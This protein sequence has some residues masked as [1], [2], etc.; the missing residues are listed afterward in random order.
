MKSNRKYTVVVTLHESNTPCTIRVSVMGRSYNISEEVQVEPF[1]TKKIE[2]YPP[3]L[4]NGDY[5][6]LAEGLNGCMFRNQSKLLIDSDAGPKIYIQTDKSVYKPK[7]L[8]QFRVVILDEHTIPV[9]I[10]EPIRI[11]V[12]DN[13][14]NRV[15]QFKDIVLTEGVFTGRFQLS[16]QPI[17]GKWEIRVTISG[18]YSH[19]NSK[20]ISVQLYTLPKFSVYIQTDENLVLD[21]P[22]IEAEIYGKYTFDKYVQGTLNVELRDFRQNTLIDQQTLRVDGL[23]LVEF[24]LNRNKLFGV[25]TIN[26]QATLEEIDTGVTKSYSQTITVRKDSYKI[27]IPEEEIEF[28]NNKPFRLR[29]HI[30]HWNDGPIWDL[31]TPV[32]MQYGKKTYETYLNEEG[33]AV[34]EFEYRHYTAFIIKFK[35]TNYR[36]PEI[37]IPYD[38][39]DRQYCKIFLKEGPR[40]GKPLEVQVR[41]SHNIPYL[42]YT[43]VGHASI[44]RMDH[45][46]LWRN[47]K[48]YTIKITPSVEMIPKSYLLVYYILDGNLRYDEITLKFPPE[49]E[50]EISITAPKQV[51]PGQELSLN[52]RAQPNSY[53]SI[54]AVDLSV[55]LLDKSY[56]LYKK[57]ILHD[58]EVDKSYIPDDDYIQPGIISGLITLTNAHYPITLEV[59]RS[60][61]AGPGTEWDF[62]TKFPETWIFENYIINN[63][64]TA[65]TLNIP[66]T[67][68]TWRI[69]AFSNNGKTGFG[70]VDGP[71]DITT[72]LPFFITFDL[73]HSVKRDEIVIISVKVFNYHNQSL[74]TR[75][76][77]FNDHSQFHFMEHLPQYSLS[78]QQPKRMTI[79]ANRSKTMKFPIKPSELGEIEIRVAANNSLFTDGI[80]KKLSVIP[81]GITK[82]QNKAIFIN[83]ADDV[84]NSTLILDIPQ[85]IVR[86]SEYI[87][88]AVGGDFMIPTLENL[89]DMIK[90]P[91]GCGEQ[92]MA[93]FAANVLILDYLK[94]T[95]KYL[96]ELELVNQAK[97]YIDM[98]YQQQLSYRHQNGGYSVFGDKHDEVVSTWLTAYVTRF[99][100]KASKYTAIESHI[101]DSA[102]DYLVKE[103]SYDGSFTS[104]GYVIYKELQ[105][106]YSL[107]AFVLLTFMEDR[108]YSRKYQINIQK[109]LEYLSTDLHHISDI[110]TLSLMAT[111]LSKSKH[112]GAHKIIEKLQKLRKESENGLTWWNGNPNDVEVTAYILM[113]LRNTPGNHSP[114]L[115]WLIEQRNEQGGFKS[116]QDTVVGLEALVK[117]SQLYK[118]ADNRNLKILY[119]AQDVKGDEKKINEFIINRE[120]A[121]ILQ[122]HELPKFVRQVSFKI[123]G[124]GY[125]LVQ[126][127][128]Q[129]NIKNDVGIKYFSMKINPNIYDGEEMDLEI[130]FTY[131]ALRHD[132]SNSTNMVIMEANLPTGFKTESEFSRDLVENEFIQRIETKDDDTKMLLYF[133]KLSTE[134]KHCVTIESFKANEVKEYKPAAVVMYDYYNTSRFN[135]EF[136]TI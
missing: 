35:D 103:Q 54:L 36:L 132:I 133:D 24:K 87:T 125:S 27:F 1:E 14:K 8:V 23:V 134:V 46:K 81:E 42:I 82:Y 92:N 77:M 107:T 13:D 28:R 113:S 115:K 49:L 78:P 47:R 58:L 19:Q 69:T 50:N 12:F 38:G 96:K 114:I 15:K 126:L 25:E 130:C 118:N 61:S 90:M 10:R 80:I 60:A 63:T 9:N 57:D 52:L 45:I 84:G 11:E 17:M 129:Y 44:V 67:I 101:L 127:S 74:D 32:R 37:F 131:H 64:D 91:V 94:A 116:S 55:Y 85:D 83:T 76:T 6:L 121:L 22:H 117:F 71:T 20:E 34:F 97:N 33:V 75:I 59:V 73:P 70:I 79:E 68:T 128:S 136:Y 88:L 86:D 4:E 89:N 95:G 2:F 43:V 72:I 31:M 108:K 29:V 41:S 39:N 100:I 124:S 106:T 66:E 51:K 62:R 65:I 111:A 123:E 18:K 119:T 112:P 48:F 98:G 135:S 30:E 3:K 109:G 102:L 53:V 56:D 120:N 7:D 105:N 5:E 21:E 104:K 40:L 16:Q 26:L 99:F 110:Y 122:K 93:N